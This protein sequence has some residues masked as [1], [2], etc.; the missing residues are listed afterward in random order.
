MWPAAPGG[1][2]VSTGWE[3][4][5]LRRKEGGSGQA[6]GHL[7]QMEGGVKGLIILMMRTV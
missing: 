4:M 6:G 5:I 2:G 3:G 7:Y 1:G